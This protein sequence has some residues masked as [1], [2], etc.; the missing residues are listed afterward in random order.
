[1][2]QKQT[3]LFSARQLAHQIVIKAEGQAQATL[4][5]NQA[6]VAQFKY[7]QQALAEGYAKALSFFEGQDAVPNFLNYMK[8]EAGIIGLCF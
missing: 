5:A 4:V 2:I 8:V 1:M 3:Q 7:R 6:D